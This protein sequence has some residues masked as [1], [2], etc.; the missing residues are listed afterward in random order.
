MASMPN[1]LELQRRAGQHLLGPLEDAMS[2]ARRY[3]EVDAFQ[4][5][6]AQRTRLVIPA[7]AL[8]GPAPV[9]R[10]RGCCSLPWR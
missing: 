7:L 4:D 3:R 5:Y 2:L 9:R 8:I 1:Q 6:I 10:W